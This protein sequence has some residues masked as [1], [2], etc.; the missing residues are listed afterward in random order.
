MGKDKEMFMVSMLTFADG[1]ISP[2]VVA[3]SVEKAQEYIDKE[4]EGSSYNGTGIH[5]IR[6]I[7]VFR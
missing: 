1:R 6:P 5:Q 4:M 2:L 7:K 3:E